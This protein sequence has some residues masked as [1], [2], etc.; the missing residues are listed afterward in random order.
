MSK[1]KST[2]LLEENR[3]LDL[4]ICRVERL[5]DQLPNDEIEEEVERLEEEFCEFSRANKAGML[6]LQAKFELSMK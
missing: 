1:V 5:T 6:K 3:Q 2:Q 4:L